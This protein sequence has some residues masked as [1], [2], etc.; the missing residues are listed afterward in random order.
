MLQCSVHNS[1]QSLAAFNT[2]ICPFPTDP[3]CLTDVYIADM[4][5]FKSMRRLFMLGEKRDDIVQSA[6]I[7]ETA[8]FDGDMR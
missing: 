4:D 2:S 7:A 3:S 6:A 8:E 1:H 5:L